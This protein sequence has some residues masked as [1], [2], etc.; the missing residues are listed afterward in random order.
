MFL[1]PYISYIANEKLQGEEQFHSKNY[2]LE[3]PCPHVENVFEKGTIKIELCNGKRYI[4]KLY[5]EIV[6]ANALARSRIVAHSN[7]A[8]FS[9][10]T[11]L[12]ETNNILFSK[13]Y[14]Y[15]PNAIFRL[16]QRLFAFKEFY[17][18]KRLSNIVKTT[19]VTKLTKVILESSYRVLQDSPC[20]ISCMICKEKYF[21]G[22]MLL[23]DQI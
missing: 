1:H 5:T 22:Y 16:V 19:N 6:A 13:N 8:S 21:S 9:I 11:T 18:E 2:L 10:K 3:M 7:T 15:I 4:K 12:C 14:C 20:L 17:M 23:T